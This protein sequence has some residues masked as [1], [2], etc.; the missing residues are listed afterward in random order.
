MSAKS[1]RVSEVEKPAK[2]DEILSYADK[3]ER[4]GLSGKGARTFPADISNELKE[5]I[6]S[7]A[8]ECAQAIGARGVLRVD[9]LYDEKEKKLYANEVNT[10]PGSLALYLFE[11]SEKTLSE[12]IAIAK[13]ENYLLNSRSYRYESGVISGKNGKA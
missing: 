12:I 1:C 13:E 8:K 9:F 6:R 11:D 3:Y 4:G 7:K 2:L 5:E 10:L